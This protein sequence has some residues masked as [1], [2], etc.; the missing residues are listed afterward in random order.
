MK[1]LISMKLKSSRKSKGIFLSQAII[2]LRPS[3]IN[4]TSFEVNKF[5]VEFNDFMTRAEERKAAEKQAALDRTSKKKSAAQKRHIE[6]MDDNERRR[7]YKKAT[8]LCTYC[9]LEKDKDGFPK[10]QWHRKDKHR[11]C[12][13]HTHGMGQNKPDK[14]HRHS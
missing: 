4:L 11:W 9:N 13:V 5:E 3:L 12:C 8:K 10:R 7:K 6:L 14:I 2:I 1:K